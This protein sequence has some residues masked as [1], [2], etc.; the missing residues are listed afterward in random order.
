MNTLSFLVVGCGRM[1]KIRAAALQALGARI[2]YALDSDP[3]RAQALAEY[4]ADLQP[5]TDLGA[6]DWARID[7]VFV[8]TPPGCRGEVEYLAREQRKPLFVEKP[9]HTS[10][11]RAGELLGLFAQ[12]ELPVGVGYMNRYRESVRR[13]RALLPTLEV[14]G[15]QGRWVCKPYAVPWWSD[16]ALSGG[17]LNEQATHLVDLV[18]FLMGEVGSVAAYRR[19]ARSGSSESVCVAL[20]LQAGITGSLLYSCSGCEKDIGLQI[21]TDRGTIGLAGWDFAPDSPAFPELAADKKSEDVFLVETAC[22]LESVRSGSSELLAP[23]L[24]DAYLT[25]LT[26]DR[27]ARS[28]AGERMVSV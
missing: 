18:R 7:G 3:A 10:L 20:D 9:L 6:V 13:V 1:G 27:I 21:F 17:A 25:Q 28:I 22:F 8:C 23:T 24:E 19:Q 12:S 2:A 26:I 14:I 16:R 15:F 4:D 11:Q 5:L